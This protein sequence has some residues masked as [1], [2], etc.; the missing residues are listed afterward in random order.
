MIPRSR[1]LVSLTLLP[2]TGLIAAS[3]MTVGRAP[4]DRS[5]TYKVI[6]RHRMA[7]SGPGVSTERRVDIDADVVERPTTGRQFSVTVQGVTITGDEAAAASARALEGLVLTVGPRAGEVAFGA[8]MM[9][10]PLS[11]LDATLLSQVL[12]SI[13]SDGRMTAASTTLVLP[14]DDKIRLTLRQELGEDTKYGH[15]PARAF[16]GT[17]TGGT[18]MAVPAYRASSDGSNVYVAQ[19]VLRDLVGPAPVQPFD[20]AIRGSSKADEPGL[21]EAIGELLDCLAMLF[22]DS[23]PKPRTRPKAEKGQDIVVVKG[24]QTLGVRFSGKVEI[25][26]SGL[27]D[28]AGKQLLR[29]TTEGGLTLEGTL[30]SGSGVPPE[31][32]G[33]W[34]RASS[35]WTASKTLLPNASDTRRTSP[36]PWLALA[37]LLGVSVATG[38]TA[39]R[40]RRC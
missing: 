26:S 25:L 21:G 2:V 32:D 9:S 23:G 34:L 39:R 8:R 3:C 19:P 1:I 17:A 31:L 22:C 6:L 7:G 14:T 18:V 10:T 4:A 40:L 37:L 20:T 15:V 29:S 12:V 13:P 28:R 33:K 27:V 5:Q 36:A 38:T 35:T 24:P 16:S 11:A 30:P